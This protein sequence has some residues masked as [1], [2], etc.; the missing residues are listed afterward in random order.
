MGYILL[1]HSVQK[2]RVTGKDVFD[3]FVNVYLWLM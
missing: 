2:L 1:M 3:L